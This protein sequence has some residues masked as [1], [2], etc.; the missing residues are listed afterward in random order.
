MFSLSYRSATHV[1]TCSR[2]LDRVVLHKE[3]YR[4]LGDPS[5][6]IVRLVCFHLRHLAL[7]FGCSKLDLRLSIDFTARDYES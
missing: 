7:C 3:D 4:C 5:N 6:T 1:G 2:G